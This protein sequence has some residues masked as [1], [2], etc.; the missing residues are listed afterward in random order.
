MET[1]YCKNLS[2]VKKERESLE[3]K[4]KVKIEIKGRNILIQGEPLDEYVASIIL[5]AVSIGF[6]IK[7]ACLLQDENFIFEKINIKSFTKRKNLSLIRARIIGTYGKT[8]K[9]IEELAGCKIV[10]KDNI[11][12][13][14]G[15]TD[16]VEYAL[17]GVTNIIKGTK[18]SNVYRYLEKINRERKK[19]LYK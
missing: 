8:K 4:L 19:N 2:E 12:G 18:Q 1:V 7:T 10:L 17:L 3:R 13:I 5:N 11:V 6:P 14:I 9:T 16:A 15:Q